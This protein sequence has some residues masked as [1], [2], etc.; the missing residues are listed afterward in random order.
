MGQLKPAVPN[1]VLPLKAARVFAGEESRQDEAKPN[2]YQANGYRLGDIEPPLPP[3]PERLALIKACAR[4]AL[5]GAVSGP[6]ASQIAQRFAPRAQSAAR[7]GDQR[8]AV[9]A[10]LAP[11]LFALAAGV[12]TLAVVLILVAVLPNLVLGA[13]FWLRLIDPPWAQQAPPQADEIHTSSI[14]PVVPSPVLTAPL[15]LEATEGEAINLPIALDGTDAVPPGSTLL[16]KGLPSGSTLSGGQLEDEMGW[17]LRPDEIGDLHLV[18][19]V[20]GSGQSRIIIQL[21]AP[22]AQILAEAST[23]LRVAA[24]PGSGPGDPAVAAALEVPLASDQQGEE[25]AASTEDGGASADETAELVP[26]PTRRPDPPSASD[27]ATNWV[28]ASAYVNLREGPSSSAAVVSVVGKGA[29]LRV[30]ARK[31]GWMQ[32]SNPA[33]AQSGWIYSSHVEGVR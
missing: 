5:R 2:G 32:V 8:L 9:Q 31:R 21:L 28:R 20:G 26:L 19:P 3:T 22:D 1:N 33:T 6:T 10:P 16:V 12:R 18:P 4:N 17:A 7:A 25:L 27:A 30:T 14:A 23:I 29:K 11:P 13:I 15:L 24:E